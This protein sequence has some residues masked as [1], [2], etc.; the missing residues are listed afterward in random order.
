[1]TRHG[2]IPALVF[3][4]AFGLPA[5]SS[6]KSTACTTIGCTS[7]A[8]LD[9]S[10]FTGTGR[11]VTQAT[12]CIDDHC[13]T[14]RSTRAN[15]IAFAS[16]R[17]PIAREKPVTVKIVLKGANG[18]VVASDSIRTRLHKVQPN[19]PKCEPIC[20]EARVHVTQAGKLAENT[21]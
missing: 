12:V 4:L 2:L 17:T 10:G 13:E 14:Q 19:G 7:G 18:A 16:A 15:P 8:D 11:V 3:V 5:C 9:L 1:M 20:Y 6:S 21:A